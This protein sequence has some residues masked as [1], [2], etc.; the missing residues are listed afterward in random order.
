MSK[1]RFFGL[2]MTA[3]G[4]ALLAFLVYQS[5]DRAMDSASIYTTGM[6]GSLLLGL[7]A[8]IVFAFG[9]HRLFRNLG[10]PR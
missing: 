10:P 4:A 1:D 2:I 7:L 8:I 9:M 5:L 3:G 6:P